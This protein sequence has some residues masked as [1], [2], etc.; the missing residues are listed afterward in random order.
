M[1]KTSCSYQRIPQPATRAVAGVTHQPA[2]PFRRAQPERTGREFQSQGVLQPLLVRSI[3]DEQYEVVAG[4]R[5]LRAAKIAELERFPCAW[6]SSPMPP[7]GK[8][9]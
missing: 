2:P 9:S 5:R 4:A 7:C 6:S 1:S 8:A 3:D